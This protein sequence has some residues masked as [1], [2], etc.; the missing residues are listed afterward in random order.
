MSVNILAIESSCDETSAAV[1]CNGKE[2]KSNIIYTQIATHKAYGGVVPEIA[3]REHLRKI[4]TVVQTAIAESGVAQSDI[5][6]IGVTEGPGLIGSLLV[7]LS[8]AK[9]M[10]ASLDVPLIGVHHLAGHLYAGIMSGDNLEPPLAGLIASGGH[11]TLVFMDKHLN[12]EVMG[13]TRD[14]APGEVLDKVARSIGLSYPGGAALEKL[15]LNGDKKAIA[16]PRAWLEDGCLDFSFSGLKSSVLNYLNRSQMKSEDVNLPDLAASFQEALFEVLAVKA[17]K[18]AKLRNANT[19]ILSGGVAA[20]GRL[21][22]ILAEKTQ[23]EGIKFHYP[24]KILCTDNGAMIGAV[25]YYKF[26]NNDFS[27]ISMNAASNLSL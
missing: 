21:R 1:I 7:G 11:S 20:N 26:I 2:I 13:E 12:F 27:D 23:G 14:D 24:P 10:A 25:A 15:A 17:V 3:S 5:D 4:S 22:E 18:A 9:A 16:F 19:L 8:Y 6:A